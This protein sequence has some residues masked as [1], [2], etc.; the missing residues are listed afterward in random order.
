MR[1][2]VRGAGL[3]ERG[4]AACCGITLSQCHALGEVAAREGLSPGELAALLGVDPSAAT[5]LTDALVQ[6]GLVRRESDPAD[7]RVVHL[8]LTPAGRAFWSRVEEAML[9]RSR[10]LL[11]RL[12]AGRREAVV[13]ALAD[14]V[15][16]LEG[17]GYLAPR[18]GGEDR[19][20][21]TACRARPL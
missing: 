11:G 5:R 16:A 14:L 7:R 2:L 17:A 8:F 13:T 1:R 21:D 19:G 12:P 6:R 15:E 18:E 3:L 9:E 20:R 10:D 4:D